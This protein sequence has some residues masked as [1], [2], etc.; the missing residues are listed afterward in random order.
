MDI[1]FKQVQLRNMPILNKQARQ[2]CHLLFPLFITMQR[3][4]LSCSIIGKFMDIMRVQC[5]GKNIALEVKS[6]N[7]GAGFAIC[8]G[9]IQTNKYLKH[10][11]T[12]VYLQK[13]RRKQ[14]L[15][16]SLIIRIKMTTQMAELYLN[17]VF[18]APECMSSK[19]PRAFFLL[20][21]DSQNLGS[22][23]IAQWPRV[24]LVSERS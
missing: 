22:G 4:G 8:G 23:Y 14:H 17:S 1:R 13:H 9:V 15:I 18:Q 11:S 10:L 2:A 20:Q 21:E 19:D 16:Y 12:S 3:V 6:V 5:I 24:C 7:V